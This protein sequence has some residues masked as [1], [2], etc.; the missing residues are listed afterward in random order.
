MRKKGA[1][2]AL[3]DEYRRAIA[4]LQSVIADLTE[5]E[6]LDIADPV[7]TNPEC[8]SIQAVLTHVVSSGFSYCIYIQNHRGIENK[9]PAPEFRRSA[10]DYVADLA[11]MQTFTDQTFSDI[12]DEE[13]EAHQYANMIQTKW[14]QAYDMEQMME[15]AIVHVLRHRR[16]IAHFKTIMR[17]K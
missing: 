10:A 13:L 8:K 12:Y 14:G 6:L 4:E 3:L 2:N 5:S 17:A 7:T 15:H 9:R 11:L 1:V 16:Q